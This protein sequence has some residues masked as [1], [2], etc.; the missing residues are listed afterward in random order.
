MNI[1][2]AQADS[3]DVDNFGDKCLFGPD[4]SGNF[5][6]H[7][8]EFGTNPGGTDEV[9]I[10]DGCGRSIPVCV[11]H[12]P[13]LVAALLEV[14]RINVTLTLGKQ[15]TAYVESDAQANVDNYQIKHNYE[16]VQEAVKFANYF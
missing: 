13:D 1:N 3:A 5:Y 14:Q 2:F 8:V 16:S 9:V 10:A 7:T 12:I 11:E 4:E 15:L 6:Y